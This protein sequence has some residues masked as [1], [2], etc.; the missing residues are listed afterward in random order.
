[1]VREILTIVIANINMLCARFSGP[2]CA[3]TKCVMIVAIDRE[4]R[5]VFAVHIMV[6]LE[7]P[8]CFTR[9]H[10]T[11]DVFGSECGLGNEIMH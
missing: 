9:A 11:I 7:L 4:L 3:M 1:V 5:C 2:R 10:G 6:E 8:L